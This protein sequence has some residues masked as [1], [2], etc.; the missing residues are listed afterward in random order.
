[1]ALDVDLKILRDRWDWDEWLGTKGDRPQLVKDWLQQFEADHW[2]EVAKTPSK[3]NSW[4]KDY[5]LKFNH[6]PADKPLSVELLK[7]VI[8]ERSQPETR[9]RQGYA[10]AY[11]RLAEFAGLDNSEIRRLG[12]G[13][14]G[15]KTIAPRSLP[16]DEAIARAREQFSDGWGWAFEAMAIYGLRPH[17]VFKVQIDRLDDNPPVLIVP[18][19]T[20]TGYHVAFPIPADEWEFRTKYELPPVRTE[21]RNN[22]QLGM[23]I[24]QKFRQRSI[25]FKP[26]DLRHSYAR[27][28]F[29]FGFPPDFLAQSMG[30]SL[31][32]HLKS[33][34][35]WWGDQP[36]L[37]VYREVL[38]RRKT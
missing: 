12:K 5:E 11:S 18:D 3:V 35:A 17:E 23:A 27:R 20:K 38:T 32:V 19:G 28:G 31:D 34:R 30:H 21:G 2:Q 14:A 26:Y 4:H 16:T 24:S 8:L 9:S 1:M 13:Y 25:G 22:N 15:G 10:F 6:L 37:K 7:R 33:Y 29:E 36:Y